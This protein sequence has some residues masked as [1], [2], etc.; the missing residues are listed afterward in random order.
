MLPRWTASV[1]LLVLAACTV[2]PPGEEPI[3][4]VRGPVP[5]S[6]RTPLEPALACLAEKA[7]KG[8]DLRFAVWQFPDRTGVTDDDGPGRYVPRAAELMMVTAL[9]RAGV[10]QVN[11]TAVAVTEWELEQALEKRLGE[12]GPVEVNGRS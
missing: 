12:G 9:A 10:R 5:V 4:T 11:R 7:P 8:R 3:A 2:P 6:V 1:P